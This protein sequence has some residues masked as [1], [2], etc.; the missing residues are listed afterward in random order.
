MPR[1]TARAASR[2][3]SDSSGE[4]AGQQRPEQ[5]TAGPDQRAGAE[6]LRQDCRPGKEVH[7]GALLPVGRGRNPGEEQRLGHVARSAG[8]LSGIKG[9]LGGGAR[10]SR[11]PAEQG[12]LGAHPVEPD[13]VPP[14]QGRSASRS[15]TRFTA[16]RA[17]SASP[18][19]TASEAS[20]SSASHSASG[21]PEA[22][23]EGALVPVAALRVPTELALDRADGGRRQRAELGGD[24]RIAGGGGQARQGRSVV[25]GRR[26]ADA[27]EPRGAGTSGDVPALLSQ[28]LG[29]LQRHQALPGDAAEHGPFPG[30]EKTSELLVDHEAHPKRSQPHRRAH[31]AD[32]LLEIG[33]MNDVARSVGPPRTAHQQRS[34]PGAAT[35]SSGTWAPGIC[36]QRN[37]TGGPSRATASRGPPPESARRSR[38]CGSRRRTGRPAAP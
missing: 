13:V 32:R 7:G 22:G 30:R 27:E 6:T 25:A 34:P 36:A 18:S 28:G 21:S 38:G 29:A 5:P 37:T 19:P 4:V 9:A 17:T 26:S 1:I 12:D 33:D 15:S 35:G 11:V 10:L 14:P 8:C 16:S 2:L 31:R 23:L 3:R 24:L 20:P